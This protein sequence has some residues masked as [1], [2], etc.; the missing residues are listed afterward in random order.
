MMNAVGCKEGETFFYS[1]SANGRKY[2][3]EYVGHSYDPEDFANNRTFKVLDYTDIDSSVWVGCSFGVF[4]YM[5]FHTL[6]ELEKMV[7]VVRG[8]E[9]IIPNGWRT[10]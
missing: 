4:P 7:K 2:I 10:V 1:C 9:Q 5:V 6:K 8:E 3:L